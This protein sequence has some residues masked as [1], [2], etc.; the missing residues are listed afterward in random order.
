MKIRLNTNH[1]SSKHRAQAK[2]IE[3]NMRAAKRGDWHA[4]NELVRTFSPLIQS[5]AEKRT[6]DAAQVREYIEA[7]KNGLMNAVKKYKPGSAPDKLQI[8]VLNCVEESMD[9]MTNGGGFFS[10]LFGKKTR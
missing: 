10:H 9:R 6:G 3:R 1:E 8:F 7:G 5:L 4:K 2:I